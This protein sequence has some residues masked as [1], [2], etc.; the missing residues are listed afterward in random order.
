MSGQDTSHWTDNAFRGV[1]QSL[2]LCKQI[3]CRFFPWGKGF[4]FKSTSMPLF[5]P[6]FNQHN[7][8]YIIKNS[9]P[10]VATFALYSCS[11]VSSRYAL[12]LCLLLFGF[13]LNCFV[14]FFFFSSFLRH[15][16]L[17]MLLSPLKMTRQY[18]SFTKCTNLVNP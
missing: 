8:L 3:S 12:I 18:G 15:A 6:L 5:M 7:V 14:P 9:Y 17:T 10:Y 2:C 4:H 1:H 13:F 11:I 16:N